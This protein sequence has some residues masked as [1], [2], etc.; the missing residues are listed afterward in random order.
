MP[1]P[2]KQKREITTDMCGQELKAFVQA[3]QK[4]F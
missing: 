2:A 4:Y 3:V 1:S